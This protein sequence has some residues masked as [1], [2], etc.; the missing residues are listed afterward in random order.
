MIVVIFLISFV[1]RKGSP[2]SGAIC[3][4]KRPKKIYG[5]ESFLN[6]NCSR[7]GSTEFGEMKIEITKFGIRKERR[8]SRQNKQL[9]NSF[10]TSHSF[11]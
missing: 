1:Y 6:R 8:E 3:R 2:L 9:L 10:I 11:I 5:F 4:S 7:T